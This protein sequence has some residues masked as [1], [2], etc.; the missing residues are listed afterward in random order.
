MSFRY[1][2]IER[3]LAMEPLPGHV[4]ELNRVASD[5]D[6]GINDVA[7]VVKTD[8]ALLGK[9]LATAN[10]A[11]YAS[12]NTVGTAEDAVGRLGIAK[13]V[14]TAMA[15]SVSNLLAAGIPAYGLM[16]GELARLA[17]LSS[18]AAEVLRPMTNNRLPG[19]LITACLL[20]DVGMIVLG[21]MIPTEKSLSLQEASRSVAD[22]PA[23][24]QEVLGV[25]HAE[26][27]DLVCE[28]W[29][30]PAPI[31]DAVRN[32][33]APTLEDGSMSHGVA[34]VVA[35]AQAIDSGLD[36]E[37]VVADDDAM[38]SAR[39]LGL[40]HDDIEWLVAASE[41]NFAFQA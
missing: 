2:V 41:Q 18:V 17:S 31:C 19:E 15:G 34:V 20:H 36:H 3:A 8:Q 33:H 6:S 40:S 27:G 9:V 23:A 39:T 10:S 16:P 22:L 38:E 12:T 24:E 13:V 7:R 1:Q 28:A 29:G 26:V 14:T 11:M 4:A 37:A 30:L 35:V 21:P 5:P 25:D 32:H